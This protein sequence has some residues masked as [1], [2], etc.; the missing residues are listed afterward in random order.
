MFL[1]YKPYI[2]FLAFIAIGVLAVGIISAGYYP[3]LS[4]NGD[5]VSARTFWKSYE[6]GA[7]YIKNVATASGAENE[8]VG[9][10]ILQIKQS[11][12]TQIIENNIIKNEVEKELGSDLKNMLREK[13]DFLAEDASLQDAAKKIYGLRFADFEE[14]VLT[15][16]ARQ[17]IL[18][19]RL[20]L[21]GQTVDDWMKNQKKNTK[22]KIFSSQFYW[23]GNQVQA[24]KM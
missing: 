9:I 12:L 15:P 13:I 23:D 20:F 3:I 2:L 22:V 16:L 14:V 19:G 4:I 6:A 24:K 8:P 5:L 18:T 11:I 21:A 7:Q 10:S 17:E 1:K